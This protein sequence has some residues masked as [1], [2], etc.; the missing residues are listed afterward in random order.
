MTPENKS[1]KIENR[2]RDSR[3]NPFKKKIKMKKTKIQKNL[4]DSSEL[5]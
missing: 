1:E 2:E 4:V 3:E 5:L